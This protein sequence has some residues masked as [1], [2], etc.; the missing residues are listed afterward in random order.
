MSNQKKKA[1]VRKSGENSASALNMI[2]MIKSCLYLI[3]SHQFAQ[4]TPETEWSDWLT[5]PNNGQIQLSGYIISQIELEHF[6]TKPLIIFGD[7]TNSIKFDV[8]SKPNETTIIDVAIFNH[9]APYNHIFLKSDALRI[10]MKTV[11]LNTGIKRP[12]LKIFHYSAQIQN[13]FTVIVIYDDKCVEYMLPGGLAEVIDKKYENLSPKH[14]TW[15][16]EKIEKPL[17]Y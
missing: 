9:M 11:T 1:I 13:F 5:M 7:I 3:D 14:E 4:K 6:T 15:Y 2:P 10:R 16:L 8:T 12:D 17:K